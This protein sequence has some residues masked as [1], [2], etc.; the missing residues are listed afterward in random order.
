MGFFLTEFHKYFKGVPMIV[1]PEQVETEL[2]ELRYELSIANGRL[3]AA[4]TLIKDLAELVEEVTEE[5][6]YTIELVQMLQAKRQ[7]RYKEHK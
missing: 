3:E 7:R 2:N 5:M 4:F 1:L 6:T